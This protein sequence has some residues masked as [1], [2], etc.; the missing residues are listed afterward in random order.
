MNHI[1]ALQIHSEHQGYVLSET[2][3]ALIQVEEYLQSE[4]FWGENDSVNVQDVLRRLQ[5][6][7]EAMVDA[8]SNE[9]GMACDIKEG[10]H[11]ATPSCGPAYRWD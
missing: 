3:A 1:K 11:V 4:K 10:Q 9:Y 7:R 8:M 2:Q 5:E 6:V